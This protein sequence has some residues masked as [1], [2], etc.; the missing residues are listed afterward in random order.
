MADMPMRM[1]MQLPNQVQS[2]MR[3]PMPVPPDDTE[4][5]KSEGDAIQSAFD[6]IRAAI[7][8]AERE[9]VMG[10]AEQSGEPSDEEQPPLPEEK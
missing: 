4:E 1:P 8:N 7:D 9:L 2:P 5:E 6:A 3:M 10:R